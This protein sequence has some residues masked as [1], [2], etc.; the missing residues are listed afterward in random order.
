MYYLYVIFGG[1]M[2]KIHNI[3]T[4]DDDLAAVAY[5]LYL[6]GHKGPFS[7][8]HQAYG[9]QRSNWRWSHVVYQN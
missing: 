3:L 2:D 7:I 1:F 9:P 6:S 8:Q 4:P 5:A